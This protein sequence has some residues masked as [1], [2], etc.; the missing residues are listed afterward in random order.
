MRA[1]LESQQLLDEFGLKSDIS[2]DDMMVGGFQCLVNNAGIF[3]AVSFP[4][5][6]C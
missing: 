1:V 6:L 4:M 3:E 5:Y 2:Y